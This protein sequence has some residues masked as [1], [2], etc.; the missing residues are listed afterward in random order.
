MR[1]GIGIS[2]AKSRNS[3]T[4]GLYVNG[5]VSPFYDWAGSTYTIQSIQ[6]KGV[7]LGSEIAVGILS[8][9]ECATSADG[10]YSAGEINLS[11]NFDGNLYIRQHN[12]NGGTY[13]DTLSLSATGGV[14]V[15]IALSGVL[16]EGTALLPFPIATA[17]QMYDVRT[18]LDAYYLLMNDIDLSAYTNWTPIGTAVAPFTGQL[19]GDNYTIYGLTVATFAYTGETGTTGALFNHT[20]T[21]TINDTIIS[22]AS[23]CCGIGAFFVYSATITAIT[24]CHVRDSYMHTQGGGSAGIVATALT[25]GAGCTI[26]NC[27][28]IFSGLFYNCGAGGIFG[29]DTSGTYINCYAIVDLVG[30]RL[31]A[32]GNSYFADTLCGFGNSAQDTTISNCYALGTVNGTFWQTGFIQTCS[33][34]DS[35]LG[36]TLTNCYSAL[37][38]LG[39]VEATV[40][41]TDGEQR[42][43]FVKD[44]L[45]SIVP[46]DT[47][48]D[49]CF[50]DE[51]IT[52]GQNEGYQESI[53]DPA[54]VVQITKTTTA[55]MKKQATFTGWNFTAGTGIWTIAEDTDYP[56]LRENPRP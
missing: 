45:G 2:L 29:S 53:T 23:I 8:N 34:G 1:L 11:A 19:D 31:T 48:A 20:D 10:E 28:A 36:S 17:Q 50:Y 15:E 27:S 18:D 14:T 38:M 39:N 52:T 4:A 42:I 30:E 46:F 12:T 25:V 55:N 33:D 13:T 54:S 43:G 41:Y 22:G 44:G 21:A 6:V 40:A 47:T 49:H 7:K 24:N 56:D 32:I 5:S 51:D 9:F 26:T 35:Y 3:Q 16:G 37:T